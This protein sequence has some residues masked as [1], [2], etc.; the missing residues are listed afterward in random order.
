MGCDSFDQFLCRLRRMHSKLGFDAVG[1]RTSRSLAVKPSSRQAKG[2]VGG[3]PGSVGE[4]V[5]LS[6]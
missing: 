2:T 3:E 1:Y 6:V 5:S 4:R